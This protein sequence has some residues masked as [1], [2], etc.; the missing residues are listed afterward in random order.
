MIEET[1]TKINGILEDSNVVDYYV[2]ETD[3]LYDLDFVVTFDNSK[4]LEDFENEI[5]EVRDKILDLGNVCVTILDGQVEDNHNGDWNG[6]DF[7]I[8]IIDPNHWIWFNIGQK[9]LHNV[10]WQC[11][12]INRNFDPRTIRL[13]SDDDWA[14]A[15]EFKTMPKSVAPSFSDL[16]KVARGVRNDF[17]CG[18]SQ[19]MGHKNWTYIYALF[20]MGDLNEYGLGRNLWE[21]Y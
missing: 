17:Y 12:V 1:K 8:D 15:D 7:Y 3:E 2:D 4:S 21:D 6:V 10:Q 20:D 19:Y 5:K 9:G 14:T 16:E 18:E 11:A 13:E